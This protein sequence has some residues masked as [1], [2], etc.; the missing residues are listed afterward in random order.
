MGDVV[1]TLD[2]ESIQAIATWLS[3]LTPAGSL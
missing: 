2:N 1:R 3:S